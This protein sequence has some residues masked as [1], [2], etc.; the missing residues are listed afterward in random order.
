ME[1]QLETE[2]DTDTDTYYTWSSAYSDTDTSITISDTISD[3]ISECISD[4]T[5]EYSYYEPFS[6]DDIDENDY[7]EIIN[8]IYELIDECFQTNL[9]QL[10]MPTF[11][12]N[13]CKYVTDIL[14][15]EWE[16]AEL[17]EEDDYDEILE[18]VEGVMETYSMFCGIPQRS[19]PYTINTIDDN[20]PSEI[21]SLSQQIEHL[22]SLPQPEQRTPEWYEFRSGLITASN[23][24]KVF[25]SQSQINSL[26]YEKCKSIELG[27][28][29]V[30]IANVNSPMH[31]GV[32]YEPVT[33]M[34][35]ESIYQTRVGE[36]G[37][38]QHP[39]ISCIGASPDG[40]N[41]DPSSNRF[42][43]MLEIKNI[44]NREITGIPKEDYWIQTQIQMETC[45][46]EKCDFVETR[47]IEYPN[48][49]SFYEDTEPT[50]KGILLHFIK[51][52][53]D[54]NAD[55]IYKYMPLDIELKPK[56]IQEWITLA[57]RDA[58]TE[59]LV[60][61][62]TIYWY[63]DQF[64]CV[65]IERNHDWFVQA[66]PKIQQVWDT[67]LQERTTGYEHRAAKKRIPK[68]IVETNDISGA[69][70]IQNLPDTKKIC[71]VKLDF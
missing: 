39:S 11:Y 1:V 67:I 24:W 61:F 15:I 46:L 58:S 51:R 38:I 70:M 47:I 21:M 53:M 59:G 69:H 65:L 52:D 12:S 22:K 18:L 63:V 44:V 40:I 54:T 16:E 6:L 30:R 31:W 8:D 35:Y 14:Y 56:N 45:K 64:S 42:G 26:I 23:L 13:I 50:H 66:A 36:F 17:C 49:Q 27:P 71:L 55:P 33:V 32:K 29:E 4:T 19:I 3:T 41:I 9:I 20:D 68:V 34:L 25:G 60:L 5:S 10:S 57:K 7:V 28:N 62:T 37:C 43:R 2:T 48:E